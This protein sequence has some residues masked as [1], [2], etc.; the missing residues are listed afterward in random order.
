MAEYLR[1]MSDYD[2]DETI[3]GYIGVTHKATEGTT[4]THAKYGPRLTRYRAQGVPVLG[5]YHVLRTP[6]SGG[7]GSL[8]AQL[9]FWLTTIDRVTPWWRDQPFIMQVDAEK[10]PYDAVT[11]PEPLTHEQA[12]AMLEPAHFADLVAARAST[13]VEFCTLLAEQVPHAYPIC[14]AS[15]GQYGDSLTGIPIDLWNAAYHTAAYPGDTAADWASYSGRVP[16]FWQ[17]TSTPYDRNAYR[18][19]LADLQARIAAGGTPV[20][21]T[22]ITKI[23]QVEGHT[24]VYASL[25]GIERRYIGDWTQ[26]QNWVT[27][28]GYPSVDTLQVTSVALQ[29]LD[30]LAGPC[31][32]GPDPAT[33]GTLE[34]VRA[35]WARQAAPQITITPDLLAQLAAAMAPAVGPAVHAE[36]EKLTLAVA[37]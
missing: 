37:P 20:A 11:L 29:D 17:F 22:T 36:L 1:D 16:V 30:T 10:W 23:F 8:A 28:H 27:Y 35:Y 4:I 13:T 34:D 15:R 3:A 32:A 12:R 21:P 6:G 2:T 14:Y 24:W 26:Y 33:T 31:V 7:N 18:G 9:D 25:N 19:T 5:A